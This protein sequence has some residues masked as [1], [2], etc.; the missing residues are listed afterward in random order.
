MGSKS[1]CFFILCGLMTI[2]FFQACTSTKHTVL[3]VSGVGQ[4]CQDGEK[5]KK[6]KAS[7][8]AELNKKKQS[9]DSPCL[10]LHKGENLTQFNWQQFNG[11]ISGFHCEAGYLKKIKVK[12]ITKEPANKPA[13]KPATEEA[14][15]SDKESDKESDKYSGNKESDQGRESKQ[16]QAH[17]QPHEESR[18]QF[19]K[20][21]RHPNFAS[22]YVLVEELEK[23][24]D[25]RYE[26]GVH[27]SLFSLGNKPITHE[28]QVP[29][30]S[31]DPNHSQKTIK[32]MGSCNR[33]S[34]KL[35]ELTQSKFKV[36]R[37]A[38]TRKMCKQA[39]ME[40]QF[41][42]ALR[43]ANSFDLQNGKLVLYDLQ[44]QAL[45]SFV[46][47]EEAKVP[48]QLHDIWAVKAV[49][50]LAWPKD[51]AGASLEINLR[52]NTILGTDGCN[53]FKAKISEVS[54]RLMTLKTIKSSKKVCANMGVA[55]RFNLALKKV[56]A[57]QLK[58]LTLN[59]LDQEGNSIISLIKV[60]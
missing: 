29:H 48:R 31:I 12:E 8:S 59:L 43:N 6:V 22:G 14:K 7:Q 4:V 38:S 15:R 40:T 3:W 5:T 37:I 26:L 41:F 9:K 52:T 23:K 56:F 33:F 45:A 11:E 60:D 55:N 27:W 49:N 57:Y 54:E 1:S 39:S 44:G 58:G 36:G 50:G 25:V 53:N 47:K 30:M 13:N 17:L 18:Q 19:D 28:L 2:V 35:N 42:S 51:A 10:Y 46:K 34:A 20:P 24:A 16:N 32:G 21:P